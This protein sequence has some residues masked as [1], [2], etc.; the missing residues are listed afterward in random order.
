L[1]NIADCGTIGEIEQDNTVVKATIGGTRRMTNY[2]IEL[3]FDADSAER[4]GNLIRIVADACGNDYLPRHNIPLHLTLAYF[5]T[6]DTSEVVMKAKY[7]SRKFAK[8]EVIFPQSERFHRQLCILH[9][10]IA[11]FCAKLT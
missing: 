8:S 7:L 3:H 5:A 9:P 1:T 6:N 11:S 4:I 2:S 10:C